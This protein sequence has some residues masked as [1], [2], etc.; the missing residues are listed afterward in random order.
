MKRIVLTLCA[1]A[2]CASIS[3]ARVIAKPQATGSD[4]GT[5]LSGDGERDALGFSA[6]VNG[7]TSFLN[8][9]HWESSNIGFEGILGF[10]KNSNLTTTDLGVKVLDR[11]KKEQNLTAYCFGMLG[12]EPYS[13]T[14]T[15]GTNTYLAAGLGAEFF[16]Q[17]LPNLSVCAE[18]G[19]GYSSPN[20]QYGNM[21]GW[22][23]SLGLKY[24]YK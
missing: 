17:G 19:L 20:S 7:G 9:R 4:S 15:S 3:F 16:F 11:L 21:A 6:V 10:N 23:P 8:Y 12:V 13:G 14:G 5:Q 24:Y 2:V 1:V 18:A 22:L